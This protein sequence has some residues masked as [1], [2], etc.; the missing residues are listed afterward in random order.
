MAKVRRLTSDDKSTVVKVLRYIKKYYVF[1]IFSILLAAVTVACT[2]YV[3]ILTGDAIDLI[4][5]QGFVDFE[6]ITAI[7]RTM[8]IVILIG[9]FAQWLMNVDRKSVV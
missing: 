1:L 5:K 2:L 6:G 7:I 3:P 4:V 9:A 8:I